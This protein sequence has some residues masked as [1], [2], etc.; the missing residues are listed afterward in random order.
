M[1][2][3]VSDKEKLQQLRNFILKLVPRNISKKCY[4]GINPGW[5]NAGVDLCVQCYIVALRQ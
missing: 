5:T 2:D 1:F 4:D 3:Q